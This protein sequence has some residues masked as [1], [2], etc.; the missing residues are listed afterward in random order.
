RRRNGLVVLARV[1]QRVGEEE[2]RL[3]ELRRAWV[4]AEQLAVERD[5]LRAR[6][7]RRRLVALRGGRIPIRLGG[8]SDC[9]RQAA[10]PHQIRQSRRD[11]GLL[12]LASTQREQAAERTLLL[13]LLRLDRRIGAAVEERGVPP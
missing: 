7:L 1:L 2:E 13:L 3:V 11:L 10:A 9:Q 4:L 6:R 12:R 8:R 5:G